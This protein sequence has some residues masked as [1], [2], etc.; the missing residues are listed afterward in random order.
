MLYVKIDLEKNK[1]N[2]QAVLAA[3]AEFDI[4]SASWEDS[5]GTVDVSVDPKLRAA[6]KGGD[7]GAAVSAALDQAH[8]RRNNG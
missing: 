1:E 4:A 5:P 6:S 3:L 8:R 2:L 7:L